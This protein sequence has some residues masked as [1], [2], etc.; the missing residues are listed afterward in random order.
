MGTFAALGLD[1]SLIV[2]DEAAGLVLDCEV[3]LSGVHYPLIDC[4]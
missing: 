2:D 3:V 4:Y 1:Q